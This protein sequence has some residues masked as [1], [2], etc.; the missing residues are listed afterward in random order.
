MGTTY[1]AE[2]FKETFE[3]SF[4]YLNGFLRNVKMYGEKTALTEPETGRMMTYQGLNRMSN[5]LAH[6][7]A[8]DGVGKNDIVMYQLQNCIEFVCCYIGPQKLGAINSPVNFRLGAGETALLLDDA[9]PKVFIYDMACAEMAVLALKSAVWQPVRVV[10]VDTDRSQP[11]GAVREKLPKGHILF[12]DYIR[13]DGYDAWNENPIPG[14]KPYIYDEVTRLYTSGTTNLP[15]GVPVNQVNEVLSAHDVMMH[16]PMN[17]TDIVMNMTPWFHRG[18][19]HAGGPTPSLYAGASM[20]IL[21][22]FDPRL[23]LSYVQKY[24][25]TFM[26][27]VPSALNML[28]KVQQKTPYCLDCL[29][30]I[31]TMGSPLEKADCEAYQKVLTPNVFNGYG[32][33]ESFWNTFL[34]PYDLPEMAGSA[35]RAC[36]DDEVRVV[37]ADKNLRAEPDEF[38]AQDN[39]E[40]GEV[41]IKTP[42]SS[43][44]YSNNPAEAEKKFYKGYMYTGD[45]G[46][47]DARG[48]VTVVGRRDDMIITAGENIYPAQLE[49][50]L[51]SHPGISDCAVV[52]VPDKIR[53]QSAAAYIVR[54]DNSLDGIEI[55]RFCDS[56]PMLSAYKKPRYYRF[57]DEIPMTA[58]GKKMHY[59]LRETAAADLAAGR[60]IRL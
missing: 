28:V 52:G 25:V 9:R 27:G 4:T 39:L 54:V 37:R 53:G 7:L 13:P 18:G 32:T 30:G 57:V 16:F 2:M 1:N 60:L 21:K 11:A 35:G 46:T 49:E 58:T 24:K 5:R 50:I 44:S 51:N 19:L 31:V 20:I 59:Q 14:D 17:A 26:I 8:A 56:H 48:F 3:H 34:R 29:K 33:T 38:C 55:S 40:V 47:W 23:C 6:A 10:A 43:Y 12:E 15:K 22:K 41:I 42:K 36:T 45:L